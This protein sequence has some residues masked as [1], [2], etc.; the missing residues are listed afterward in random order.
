LQF[1]AIRPVPD[2]DWIFVLVRGPFEY[3]DER[4]HKKYCMS[5]IENLEAIE[6]LGIRAFVKSER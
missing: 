6:K 4:Y 2:L 3:W 1:P 5:M